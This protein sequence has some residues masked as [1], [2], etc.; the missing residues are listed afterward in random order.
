MRLSGDLD[1]TYCTNI[2]PGNGW[3]EV[4][5]NIRKFAPGL[6][7]EL[8]P[9]GAFGLGL[10]LSAR[11][12]RELLQGSRLA[13]FRAYL[14]GEG[15]YVA[16]LNGF[17]HG[18]FHG[19]P[20]KANVYAPDWREEARVEY[21]LDLI[22]VLR[23]LLPEG[24][25]GGVS[26]APLSYKPWVRP[27]GNGDWERITGNVT[28][29]AEA[30]VRLRRDEGKFIH[31]DI[32]PEPDCLIEDTPETLDF[33]RDWLLP[34]G[35]PALAAKLGA[36]PEESQELL[37]EHIQLCFDCCHFAVEFEDPLT[38]I[39]RFADAGIRMGRMQL[40]SAL[41]VEFPEDAAEAARLAERLSRFADAT[42]LHQV[43][44]NR[45]GRLRKF[46]DLADALLHSEPGA[47]QWRIHFHVPLFADGYAP[48]GSTQQYV[49]TS[50]E[51][52]RRAPI[53]RHLEIET[54]TWDV[55]P[56]DLRS[57]LAESIAREY[58]WA[59][60]AYASAPA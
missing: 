15:M 28:R 27:P 51:A 36:T 9:G 26:T 49:R 2:H 11:E 32:E 47:R 53:T 56:E 3:E 17:P 18:S 43:T 50:I 23:G 29:V 7:R 41:E 21:T 44:E 37:L 1:L 60:E 8:S 54:Y 16:L 35:A 31:L 55:L 12:A 46:P 14:D 5:A 22:Q 57:G 4:S 52:A 39:R 59:L 19:V 13:D 33:Y 10:R 38:A 6:K 24:G 42:Y 34:S 58:H 20:V 25:D 40:S 45:G 48:L 30:L